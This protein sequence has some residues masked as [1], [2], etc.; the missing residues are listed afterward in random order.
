M[1]KKK[2]AE[3]I[4]G[5]FLRFRRA[6]SGNATANGKVW[7]GIADSNRVRFRTFI[8]TFISLMSKLVTPADALYTLTLHC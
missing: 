5:Y 2:G 1:K 8:K 4:S 3:A 7:R 6:F